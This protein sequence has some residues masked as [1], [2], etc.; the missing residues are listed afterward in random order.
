VLNGFPSIRLG[1]LTADLVTDGKEP[2]W[3]AGAA[4][5]NPG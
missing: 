4:E 5:V 3:L 1:R 2:R